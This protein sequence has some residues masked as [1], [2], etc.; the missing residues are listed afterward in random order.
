MG[1]MTQMTGSADR[2]LQA[3]NMESLSEDLVSR[4]AVKICQESCP[5]WSL[6]IT[7]RLWRVYGLAF[8]SSEGT[9]L[10]IEFITTS[11]MRSLP[12]LSERGVRF[13]RLHFLRTLQ[14]LWFELHICT[15]SLWCLEFIQSHLENYEPYRATTNIVKLCRASYTCC[16]F[17]VVF[18]FCICN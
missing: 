6:E 16:T 13:Q 9:M 17:Q 8:K 1:Q 4:I 3:E 5:A 18:S 15:C 14:Y 12:Q 2:V 7:R 11:W 10:T